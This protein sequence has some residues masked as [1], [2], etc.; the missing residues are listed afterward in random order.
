M[1]TKREQPYPWK[2]WKTPTILRQYDNGK[3]PAELLRPISGGGQLWRRAA[4]DWNRMAKAAKADGIEIRNVSRG[5][6]SYQ[7]QLAMWVDR[8]QR[9]KT[10]RKPPVTRVWNQEM[11]W[12]KRGASPCAPPGTS[13]HGWGCAQ[14]INHH[15]KKAFRWMCNNAPRWNFYLQAPKDSPY[16]EDWHW[17]WIEPDVR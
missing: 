7:T 8:W 6:R 12:L 9:R 15:D 10:P 2:P 16:R 11:W 1:A 3:L 13:P 14:D 5:Y 4:I 17:H